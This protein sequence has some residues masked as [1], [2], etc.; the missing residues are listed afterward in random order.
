M[1]RILF[2]TAFVPNKTG[3]GENFSRQLIN[4]IAKNHLVDLIFFKY[5]NDCDYV[6][7]SENIT[8]VKQFKNSRIIKIINSIMFPFVFPL[9]TVR[10][11]LFR[12]IYIKKLIRE[13]QYDI[14]LFDFSQTFLFAKFINQPK[15]IL[16]CHDVI[17]QRYSRIYKGI[18]KPFVIKSEKFIFNNLNAS[19]FC[20]SMKDKK[21]LESLY[22]VHPEV[23]SLYFD[24]P[25]REAFPLY[26]GNYFVLFANW[27]RSDN[28]Y[29]LK[30]FLHYVFPFLCYDVQIIIIGAGLADKLLQEIKKYQNVIYLG[31][32][33]NPYQIISNAKALI[34]PL[35]T[36]AGIKV[37]VM[38]SLACGTNVIGT[39]I[40]FEG[41]P[42]IFE[43]YMIPA[44]N[45][46]EF[47]KEINNLKIQLSEKKDLKKFFLEY[48][49]K[50][51]IKALIDED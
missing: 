41:V 39:K 20:H 34:S 22:S 7:E 47:I 10:F 33:D 9:F 49:I 16:N 43:N 32:I 23:T 15:I 30:W 35:F 44:E 12:L 25:V 46:K 4:D 2:V 21:L 40:S 42:E 14:I 48:D 51:R 13:N 11:N 45:Q 37:K 8:V 31:F 17:A 50:N 3:A 19:V 38:E 1:K 18:L 5:L 26:V 36:G 6:N 29:G 27:K 28:S 24:K